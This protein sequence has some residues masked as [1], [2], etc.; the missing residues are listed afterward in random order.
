[1]SREAIPMTGGP[2]DCSLASAKTADDISPPLENGQRDDGTGKLV[3]AVS[4]GGG[5][6]KEV[7][8]DIVA[9]IRILSRTLFCH[10]YAGW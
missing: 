10:L 1:M 3:A 6:V 2:S 8:F 9:K 5:A 7:F 4:R